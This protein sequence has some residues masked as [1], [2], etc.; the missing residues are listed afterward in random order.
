MGFM[1]SNYSIYATQQ[2]KNELKLSSFLYIC[3]SEYSIPSLYIN[4]VF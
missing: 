2:N 3:K 4:L 1:S